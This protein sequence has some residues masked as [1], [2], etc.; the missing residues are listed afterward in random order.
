MGFSIPL[1]RFSF[2]LDRGGHGKIH[3]DDDLSDFPARWRFYQLHLS[4]EYVVA[5]CVERHAGRMPIFMCRQI[6]PFISERMFNCS[7]SEL[8]K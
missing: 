8:G 3:F 4:A 6:V 7:L 5:L 2:D 1:D